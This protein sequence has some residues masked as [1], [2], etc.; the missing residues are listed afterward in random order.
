MH[1]MNPGSTKT[2]FSVVVLRKNRKHRLKCLVVFFVFVAL[3]QSV[4]LWRQIKASSWTVSKKQLKAHLFQRI[5]QQ[6]IVKNIAACVTKKLFWIDSC[7]EDA[8]YSWLLILIYDPITE[9]LWC[10]RPEIT[11]SWGHFNHSAKLF[12][13]F[14]TAYNT[15]CKIDKSLFQ[16]FK[17]SAG[18][19]KNFFLPE[20]KT[21][22]S[23]DTLCTQ[24]AISFKQHTGSV[25]SLGKIFSQAKVTRKNSNHQQNLV[26]AS[27]NKYPIKRTI[28]LQQN[29]SQLL[30]YPQN[31]CVPS[32]SPSV[33]KLTW[34]YTDLSSDN[35]ANFSGTVPNL[36][37]QAKNLSSSLEIRANV[38][39][40]VLRDR[41]FRLHKLSLLKTDCI[42]SKG[43]KI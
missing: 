10:H 22:A 1:K 35:N 27:P 30:I 25:F 42:K 16:I 6:L 11:E 4:L 15:Y 5:N 43:G 19:S 2:R 3:K 29:P 17:S 38:S 28:K 39:L 37:F 40:F 7:S 34:A 12:N 36:I 32:A 24:E 21:L 41:P 23:L 13:R 26:S 9:H 20:D 14:C 31:G 8:C 18:T 33:E